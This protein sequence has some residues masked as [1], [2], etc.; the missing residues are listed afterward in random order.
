MVL[1]LVLG[2][3]LLAGGTYVAAYLAS[4][5]RVPV[6]TTVAGVDIG[7]HRPTSAAA[8]LRAGLEQRA[9]TPFT[10]VI[11]GRTQQVRPAQ[12]GLAVDYT[13]S[14]S[15]AGA[16]RSWRPSRLWT[17]FTNGAS[18]Q[19]VVT[20]DQTRLGRLLDRLDATDGRTATDG[21]VVFRRQSFSI[22]PA[23]PG[24]T[25]DPKAAG[26]AF[27]GAY[28]SDDP[29]VEL[30][31]TPTSPAI[32]TAAVHRFVRRFANP[33]M[34]AAVQLHF[35]STTLHLSPADYGHL[36]VARRVGNRLRPAV[37]ARPLLR[38]ARADLAGSTRDRPQPA[39][40]V[41]DNGRPQVTPAVPGLRFRSRD[42]AHALL[43]A[44]ASPHRTAHVR[45]TA[46]HA[47]FTTAD[48]R[49]LRIRSQLTS[50]AVPLDPG[51]HPAVRAAASALDGALLRPGHSLSL[52]GQVG[53]AT[54]SGAAGDALA[55][56]LF[57]A[58]WLGGLQVTS[59][60]AP[61]SYTGTA[62]AGRDASLRGGHDLVVHDDTRY[63][64]L[65]S[66]SVHHGQLE[67]SL[68]STPHW[69]VT[70]HTSRHTHVVDPGRQVEHG[71]SCTPQKGT[72]GFQVTVTRSF[73]L[74]GHVDHTSSYAVRYAP[75]DA[76]V[77]HGGHHHRHH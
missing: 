24:Y 33:A 60:A 39:T 54:P 34:A 76:V 64:V 69:T 18:Y 73:A 9:S 15:R 41:L 8:T 27:W 28:L 31:L 77:C 4:D 3:T 57:N 49:H 17:Y 47:S 62:P 51:T 46:A 25:I 67:I 19:P 38:L 52:R 37:Q 16:E 21:G 32:D 42:I 59:H 58:A 13:A 30:R 70:S 56:G 63:G 1:A 6:G 35:G 20:L 66:A 23:R 55:T 2:L 44:I 75:V 45:P 22:R 10:V 40:V 68:W 71:S 36:L 50:Y 61:A 65:V 53:S 43:T 48:A 11:N 12:V 7:G 29:S 26:A 74:G 5:D 72:P 14:V